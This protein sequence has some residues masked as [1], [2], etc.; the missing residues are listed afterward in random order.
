[1]GQNTDTICI[2]NDFN[3]KMTDVRWVGGWLVVGGCE[4]WVGVLDFS[5][6]IHKG[7]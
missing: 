1:M 6:S 4:G 5:F 3:G 7:H 2:I